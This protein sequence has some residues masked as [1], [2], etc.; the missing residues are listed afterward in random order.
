MNAR[1]IIAA[2][3]MLGALSMEGSITNLND[4]VSITI[5]ALQNHARFEDTEFTNS[6]NVFLN[7]QTGVVE[8]SVAELSLSLSSA[9]KYDNDANVIGDRNCLTQNLDRLSNIVFRIDLE[10]NS[11]IRYAAAFQ[12]AEFLNEDDKKE[13]G[14]DFSTNILSQMQYAPPDMN[15]TNFWSAMIMDKGCPNISIS[16]AFK[17][18]AALIAHDLQRTNDVLSITN[19]MPSRILGLFN[20]DIDSN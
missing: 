17:L 3:I 2:V 13:F 20:A 16:E 11:W 7:S 1:F 12:Y 19:Q 18:N 8:R 5:D 14:Y 9:Y 15:S 4:L 6:V 10:S